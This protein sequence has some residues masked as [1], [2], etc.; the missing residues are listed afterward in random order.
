[1]NG[2]QVFV[3]FGITLGIMVTFFV[4]TVFTVNFLKELLGMH[5]RKRQPKREEIDDDESPLSGF[6]H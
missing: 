5:N 3:G 1:M 4:F 6:F 2:A